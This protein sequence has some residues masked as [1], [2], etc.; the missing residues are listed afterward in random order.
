MDMIAYS[1]GVGS[2]FKEYIN[3]YYGEI[4]RFRGVRFMKLEEPVP[5]DNKPNVDV[6]DMFGLDEEH[7]DYS[8]V[9]K[10]FNKYVGQDVIYIHTRCGD[11][12]MGYDNEE[13]NYVYCGAK[14]WE[15]KHKDLFIEHITDPFDQTYCTHFFK[16]VVND[17]YEEALKVLEEAYN[18]AEEE[19]ESIKDT[20][21]DSGDTEE[22][23]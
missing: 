6:T 20:E 10:I 5:K 19:Y 11:C 16:A 8:E 18:E 9:N 2:P 1:I 7:E 14:D 21:D 15:E 17:E 13:S 23:N 3:K 22:N 4:P 12:G